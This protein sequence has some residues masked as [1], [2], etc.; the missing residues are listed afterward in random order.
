MKEVRAYLNKILKS[1]ETIV[2]ACSGGPDSMCLLSLLNEYKD[3]F[4]LKLICAHVNHKLRSE[5]DEECKMVEAFCKHYNIVFEYKELLEYIN[6]DFSEEDARKRR[7]QFFDEVMHKYGADTLM[8]AHHGDDLIETILMRITRGSNLSGFV[9]IKK[10][11]EN[12]KYRIVRPLL[13]TSKDEIIKYLSDNNISYAIDKTN[14]SNAYT[15]NRYRHEVLPF[16]KK[17]N[18][19]IHKKYSKFSEELEEY[20]KFVNEYIK[21]KEFVVDNSIDINKLKG[22]SDFIKRKCIELLVKVI[23][24]NDLF[25]VSDSEVNELLKLFDNDNKSIDL[26]NGYKGVSSYGKIMI[27]KLA[28]EGFEEI[29]FDKDIE[30]GN[31]KFYYNTQDG[32][33]SNNCIYLNSS[34]IKLPLKLRCW[35]AGDRIN[36]KNL[37]GTK[38]V[39]DIFID[40][41][42][43]KYKRNNYPILVDNKNEI[44]W[45]PNVKKSQFAKDKTEKYD[46]IIRCEAR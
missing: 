34:E 35:E 26:N 32:N 2:V 39:S 37:N 12:K 16:L 23:Q 10:V 43:P 25:D 3:K 15:R 13:Y 18:K 4:N 22:E 28:N 9:G 29:T 8:T 20:D 31:F 36:V 45:I 24:V 1:N 42:I 11:S 33:D 6:G 44:L 30:L 27:L 38:K 21:K 41:K 17:E 46:I 40:S 14:E 19:D 7:Y 5:S